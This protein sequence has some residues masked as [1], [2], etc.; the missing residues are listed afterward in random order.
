MACVLRVHG[1]M[2][3]TPESLVAAVA[4]GLDLAEPALILCDIKR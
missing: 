1:V 4:A 3:T 2:G